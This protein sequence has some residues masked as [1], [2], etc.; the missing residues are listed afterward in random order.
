LIGVQRDPA[1]EPV[2]TARQD[3][4]LTAVAD[5]AH[6]ILVGA[7][8]NDQA[9]AVRNLLA[10]FKR[11]PQASSIAQNDISRA[12]LPILIA[13]LLLLLQTLTRR[14]MALVGVALLVGVTRAAAQAPA[15]PPDDAWRHGAFREAAEGYLAQV[16][17]GVGGDTAWY[18]LGTAALAIGDTATA[19]TALARVAASLAPDLRFR[20]AY[21]LGLLDLRRAAA[22]TARARAY[23]EQAAQAYRQ[24]LLLRPDDERAKWNL[25]LT[26]RRTPPPPSGGGGTPPPG[27][28]G[29]TG[30][31]SAAPGLTRNQAEQIA[32][33]ERRT[34]LDRN[35]RRTDVRE[36]RGKVDW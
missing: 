4:V 20:A 19:R 14:S 1:G 29:E 12:W 17:S 9:G 3:D 30:G 7:D 25:E 11:S 23:L 16:R 15:N 36:S 2:H 10:G 22:D 32:A 13:A 33:E 26:L 24:A 5:A 18:N 27:A 34:L 8:V 28:G 6:G 31:T 35:R 21:N